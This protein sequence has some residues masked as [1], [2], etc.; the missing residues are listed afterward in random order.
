MRLAFIAAI[1]LAACTPTE[2]TA[3][4]QAADVVLADCAQLPAALRACAPIACGQPHMLVRDFTI[5][6]QIDGRDGGLCRYSQTVP[7]DMLMSCR[8]S[9]AGAEEVASQHEDM[10]DGEFSFSY[11]S[12]DPEQQN[13]MTR[14]C[15]LTGPDG[16]VIP[17]G[18]TR[19]R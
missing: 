14:E 13:A 2:N 3:A 10:Q 9:E 19:T 17:W 5:K 1:A 11:S 8:F 15:V 18:T 7:G 12:D 4:P 16:A 6:H